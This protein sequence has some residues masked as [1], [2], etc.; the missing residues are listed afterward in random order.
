MN[1]INLLFLGGAKR[2]SMARRFMDAAHRLGYDCNIYSYEKSEHEAI[3]CEATVIPGLLWRDKNIYDDLRQICLEK[4][5][6]AIIPF[7]DGAVSV[8]AELKDVA[9]VPTGS[10]KLAETMFD[11]VLSADLFEKLDLPIPKTYR[12]GDPSLQ[13][14]AKPRHGSASKGIIE[15]SSLEELDAVMSKADQ[16]LVQQ[17]ID[18]REEYTVDCYVDTR[19]GNIRAVCP[20]RRLEVAGGEVTRT[21][22]IAD[23]EIVKL[24]ERTLEVTGLIGAVTVQ[25]LRD[26]DNGKLMLMEINPRLGGGAVCS[27]AAGADM[28]ELI[29]REALNLPTSP[30]E[31]TPGVEIA[32]YPAEV[33]FNPKN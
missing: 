28:P 15:I 10:R 13:L 20:R 32:R 25:M 19:T 31:Y 4:D 23:D 18:R 11:K 17:R 26:L 1:Q 3:A 9:F 21:I 30:L 33:V 29:L 24:A 2:V 8:A 27:V 14:I 12:A 22:T 7:V 16:Y 6:K 5:I